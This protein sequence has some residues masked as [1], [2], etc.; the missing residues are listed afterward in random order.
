MLRTQ[1]HAGDAVIVN[2]VRFSSNQ[3]HFHFPHTVHA[4][5]PLLRANE[6]SNHNGFELTNKSVDVRRFCQ[7]PEGGSWQKHGQAR[8]LIQA[9]A[10]SSRHNVDHLSICT[11]LEHRFTAV[12]ILT[13]APA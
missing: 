12:R 6:N 4:P 2:K 1:F 7:L 9:A 8:I 13:R 11:H 5:C 10:D 3:T